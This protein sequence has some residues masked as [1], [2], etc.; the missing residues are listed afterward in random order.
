MYVDRYAEYVG[1]LLFSGPLTT[2]RRNEIF[3]SKLPRSLES[4]GLLG[5]RFIII[6]FRA[7]KT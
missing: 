6:I 5:F 3:V 2:A 7:L 4:G 1:V